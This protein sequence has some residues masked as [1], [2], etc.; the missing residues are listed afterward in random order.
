MYNFPVKHQLQMEDVVSGD[1][2]VFCSGGFA[3][4]IAPG[5]CNA[6]ILRFRKRRSPS[7]MQFVCTSSFGG[8]Q[9]VL[10]H[11]RKRTAQSTEFV[12]S[13]I[14]ILSVVSQVHWNERKKNTLDCNELLSSH[15]PHP[16]LLLCIMKRL[17][18]KH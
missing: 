12:L 5:I 4:V 1:D 3:A 14:C 9:K 6:V 18:Y 13:I 15:S 16:F 11:K 10:S 8:Q 2:L 7:M 17:L